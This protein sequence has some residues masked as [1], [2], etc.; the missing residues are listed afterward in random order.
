[1]SNEAV[2]SKPFIRPTVFWDLIEL[3]DAMREEDRAEVFHSSKSTPFNALYRGFTISSECSTIEWQ[4]RVVAIFGVVGTKGEAGSPWML[5]SDDL[6]RCISL[7]R[8]CRV[9]MDRWLTEY[10]YLTNACWAKNVV[11]VNWI[12]WL[13]FIFDGSDVRNGEA[14]LH[15]HKEQHV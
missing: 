4:G 3:G 8:E 5:G 6:P 2:R 11:H 15:F 9:L 1:M 12:Q 7:L 10:T 13:G 14:F